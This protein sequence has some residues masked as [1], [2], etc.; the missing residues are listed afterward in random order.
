[1]NPELYI[2]EALQ[3]SYPRGLREDVLNAD[4]RNVGRK[5]SLTDQ[6]RHCRNLETKGHVTIVEGQDHNTIKIT[7]D[8]LHR[9]AE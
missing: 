8:G 4:M 9:L 3:S 2:L 6:A 5:M 1:M 7:P